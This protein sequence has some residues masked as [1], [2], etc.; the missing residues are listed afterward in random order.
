MG[1]R[2]LLGRPDTSNGPRHRSDRRLEAHA[3]GPSRDVRKAPAA[4][5]RGGRRCQ[6]GVRGYRLWHGRSGERGQAHA[7]A[8]PISFTNT[9]S[10]ADTD[11]HPK[12]NVD[13]GPDTDPDTE[14]DSD[15]QP[16]AESNT[17]TDADP[18]TDS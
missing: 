14:S 8:E 12:P 16:D 6:P 9:Y 18:N 3:T 7:Q 11:P 4:P 2:Q 10:E 1:E 5:V 13:A 15:T 17:N